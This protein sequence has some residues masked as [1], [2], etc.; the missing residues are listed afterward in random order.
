MKTNV[1]CYEGIQRIFRNA[2]VRYLREELTN[3]YPDDFGSRLSSSFPSD[4]WETIKKHA[5]V[6][7]DTGALSNPI[8]DDF[9][10]LS[11]NHF[12]GL[13][14]RYY[15]TLVHD[16]Q[17]DPTKDSKEKGQQKKKLL[18]WFKAVKDLR[19]PLSHPAD[20]D[21][22]REDAFVLLDCARRTLLRIN[23]EEDAQKI[24]S[25]MDQLYSDGA[26]AMQLTKDPLEG[27]LPAR[28]SI[29]LE[30]FG[31]RAELDSLW[32]WFSDPS[33][34]RWALAGEGGLGKSALAYIFAGEV[35]SKAPLP[36]QTVIWL[37]A[38]KKR[39]VEGKTLDISTPDFSNLES[40]LD[41][42]LNHFGWVESI[43]ET[44]NG[45]QSQVIRL[46]DEFPAFI[47]VDDIDSLDAAN[48]D[49]IEFFSFHVPQ[50]KSKV[51]FTSRRTI[52]GMGGTTTL[53][54]GLAPEEANSVILS[55]C[56][57]MGFDPAILS[58]EIKNEIIS[59]TQGS[60]LYIEDLIRLFAIKQPRDAVKLWKE[61]GGTEAR[62]YTLGRECE[63]LTDDALKVLLVACIATGRTSLPEIEAVLGISS[64]KVVAALQEL[65]KLFLIPLPSLVVGE[66]RFEVNVNTRT[67]VYEV[68][69]QS[70][71]F[72]RL[73]NTYRRVTKGVASE[74]KY[75]TEG[76]VRQAVFF[77]RV[78]K[79]E[80]A[81]SILTSAIAMH[82]SNAELIGL[83]GWVYKKW[84]Q[85]RII[86]ARERFLR[87]AQL[88][89]SRPETMDHWCTME[90]NQQE[91]RKAV[92]AAEKA[93]TIFPGN[94]SFL[95]YA[96]YA[97]SRHGK[98]LMNSF[99]DEK[100]VKELD[101]AKTQLKLALASKNE[102]LQ[103]REDLDS[104]I[105]R[106]LVLACEATG[107][108]DGIQHYFKRWRADDPHDPIL[109]TEWT[110]ISRILG[111]FS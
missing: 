27:Q 36:F 103:R 78:G 66:Q 20:E 105:Y 8:R 13:F 56:K 71:L 107:D 49:V 89:C 45:K 38:K 34:R 10:V 30:F 46:L 4:Q 42:F 70:E 108:R 51:L 15:E 57:Q 90:I 53:V 85:P 50:T 84:P 60:P 41:L 64:N 83:L 16:K 48:E 47:I 35:K 110:R 97:R 62:R 39:F 102:L 101:A 44:I 91:W 19:D 65:Q 81:E 1:V 31:R 6:H 43:D 58:Q 99:Q 2:I 12:F 72:R 73:Q 61:K 111:P 3:A 93:L 32:A 23:L 24:K 76:L 79:F 59:A 92:E 98:E 29:V 17:Q 63:L 88:K 75:E 9:D 77:V 37:S 21:F 87:A 11:V 106:S 14:D 22:S 33:M 52:F 5:T 94:K 40:A 54:K 96:G 67:L 68:H 86:D 80:E 82:G 26:S 104:R 55:R 25:L 7:R 100:G 18:E 69:G 74:G 28:E 95:F 109:D